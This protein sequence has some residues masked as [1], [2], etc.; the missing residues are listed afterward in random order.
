[1]HRGEVVTVYARTAGIQIR[2]VARA[3]EDGARGEL[4]AVDSLLDHSGFHA[5]VSGIR[6][7]EV[8]ARSPRVET[9][10]AAGPDATQR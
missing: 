5:R 9:A 10:E 7:V 8:Y 4:V 1:V 6:E 2:T 3:R